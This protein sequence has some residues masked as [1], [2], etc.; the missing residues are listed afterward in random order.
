MRVSIELIK[1]TSQGATSSRCNKDEVA[2]EIGMT[3]LLAGGSCNSL[4]HADYSTFE[5]FSEGA[6]VM[7]ADRPE[8]LGV[9]KGHRKM[10]IANNKSHGEVVWGKEIGESW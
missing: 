9:L 6:M 10:R 1:L 7:V 4:P 5:L 2:G 3:R 8:W